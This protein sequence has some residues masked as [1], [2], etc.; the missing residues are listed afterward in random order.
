MVIHRPGREPLERL[1]ALLE[2]G[3]L[4]PV[5]DSTYALEDT[6]SAFERYGTGEFR[7]KV[8]ITHGWNLRVSARGPSHSVHM[9]RFRRI[10]VL[11]AVGAAVDVACARA[12]RRPACPG[13]EAGHGRRA[14]ARRAADRGDAA[15]RLPAGLRSPRGRCRGASP[16]GSTRATAAT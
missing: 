14:A 1:K 11:G 12:R 7:G 16:P 3:T 8:V 6:R 13:V 9:T 5:I 2:A 10:V 15:R 4:V